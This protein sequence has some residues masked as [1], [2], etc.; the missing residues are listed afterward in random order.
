MTRPSRSRRFLPPIAGGAPPTGW[1]ALEKWVSPSGAAD[2]GADSGAAP[3]GKTGWEALD[4]WVGGSGGGQTAAAAAPSGKT[5]WEALDKWVGGGGEAA[6][7][8]PSGK[9]GW[10]ALDKWV[11][12]GGT[13]GESVQGQAA[14]L[15]NDLAQMREG[16]PDVGGA[17]PESKGFFAWLKRLFGGK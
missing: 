6:A 16:L 17:Q 12:S 7:A 8:A 5:G 11:P 10:E 1:E 14:E 13:G 3:S 4:K 2:A 9:T 15:K